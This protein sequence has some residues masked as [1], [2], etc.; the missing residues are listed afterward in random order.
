L[1]FLLDIAE[2]VVA[3]ALNRKESRGG[4]MRDDY[5]ERNDK[6]YLVHTMAYLTGDATSANVE[7][8]I[9]IDWKPV[10]ITNY[11]PMERKY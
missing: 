8:H 5:P 10:V 7:D 6:D 4:H 3:S 1:G 11:P 2:V 9:S